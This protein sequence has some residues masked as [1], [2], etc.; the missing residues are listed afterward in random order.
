LC[1]FS[2]SEQADFY[3]YANENISAY[4]SDNSLKFQSFN[5]VPI[6]LGSPPFWFA[7]MVKRFL[8]GG[9]E[10]IICKTEKSVLESS[11]AL[12]RLGTDQPLG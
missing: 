9:D 11:P 6:L 8:R 2:S 5:L 4:H 1:I 12:T 7:A 3:T 10:L